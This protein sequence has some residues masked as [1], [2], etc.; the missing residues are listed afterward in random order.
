MDL[1]GQKFGRLTVTHVEPAR[2]Q[3]KVMWSCLCACGTTV[4]TRGFCLRSGHTQSCGC[5]Q[6]ERQRASVTKHGH[7]GS[8]TIS[9]TYNSWEGMIQRC[10]NPKTIGWENYGGRGITVCKRWR[11]KHGFENFLKDMGERPMGTSIDRKNNDSHY[12]P[13]NC[14]WATRKEQNSNRRDNPWYRRRCS[15]RR[16]HVSS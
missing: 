4:S 16:I 3:K 6:R 10:T 5:L 9:T 2:N 11:G 8:R 14:R 1:S 12:T 7:A 15:Q 13:R